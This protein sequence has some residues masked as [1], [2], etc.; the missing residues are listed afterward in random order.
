LKNANKFSTEQREEIEELLLRMDDLKLYKKLEVLYYATLGWTNKTISEVSHYSE[1]RVSDFISEYTTNGIGYFTEEHRKGG[2]HRNLSA[3]EEKKVV[4]KFT[5]QAQKGQVIKL[6]E[7][8]R[9]YDKQCGKTAGLS[10]FYR[11]LDRM[12]WRRVMPRGQHPQKADDE[13]VEASKK[14]TIC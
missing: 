11:L 7:M 14:L 12:D 3:E 10:T 8:K 13:A 6:D 9:E 2:N 1:S 4:E 5:E